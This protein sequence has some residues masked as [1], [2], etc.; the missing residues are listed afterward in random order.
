[1]Q[2]EEKRE[3]ERRPSMGNMNTREDISRDAPDIKRK[4]VHIM[5]IFA[6]TFN[7]SGKLT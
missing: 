4:Q 2:R 1:M 7:K 6:N 3:R 5:T